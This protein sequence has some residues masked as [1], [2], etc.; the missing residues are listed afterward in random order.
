MKSLYFIAIIPPAE[1]QKE[2][3][4]FKYEAALHFNSKRAL[5]S[6]AHITLVPPFW[7]TQDR[8]VSVEEILK[9]FHLEAFYITLFGFDC[10]K[11][12]VVFV[13]IQENK[14]LQTLYS[15]LNAQLTHLEEIKYDDRPFHP[16]MTIAFKDLK[17]SIFSDAWEYFRL[18]EYERTFLV[19]ALFLLKYSNKEWKI[20]ASFNFLNYSG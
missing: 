2:V 12:R 4:G 14:N 1:I 16:H 13:N 18:R 10:F 8:L 6:P 15:E 17:K 20:K 11:P 7:I 9:N 3:S 5:N 19:N